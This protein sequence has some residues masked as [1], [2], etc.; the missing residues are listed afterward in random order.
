[1][2]RMVLRETLALAGLGVL[3]GIPLAAASERVLKSMLFGVRTRD[4]VTVIVAVL[5]MFATAALAG[6]FPARRAANVDP[7]VALRY[8]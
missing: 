7:M 4:P 3:A 1:M 2:L 6:Y 5:M 8:E